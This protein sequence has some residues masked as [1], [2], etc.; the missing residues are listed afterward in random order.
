MEEEIYVE[1]EAIDVQRGGAVN[2]VNGKVGDVVLT[3]E[4]V[5]AASVEG[6]TEEAEAREAADEELGQRI[7]NLETT[8]A[9]KADASAVE[10]ALNN[11][12]NKSD[13]PTK[14][15]DLENDSDF[16][17]GTEVSKTV[18]AAVGTETTARENA[19]TALQT[20]INS[21]ASARASADEALAEALSDKLDASDY[22]VDNALSSTSEN[23]VQN[24]VIYAA[25]GD[26]ETVLARLNSGTGAVEDE[27]E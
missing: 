3:A 10:T 1:P 13:V 11:K 20:A 17:T 2:S 15:S 12:A 27:S 18:N 4:D 16:Q 22:V 9:E 21:E 8:V 23:P 24:K 19:D 26:V 7:D 25:I 5:G 14:T 6:Q